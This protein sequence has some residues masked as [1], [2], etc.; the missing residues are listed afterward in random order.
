MT[1]KMKNKLHIYDIIELYQDMVKNILNIK[2]V[3]VWRWLCAI[4]NTL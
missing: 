2:C 4:N 3:S 1:V